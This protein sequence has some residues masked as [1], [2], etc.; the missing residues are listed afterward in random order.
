MASISEIGAKST[1]KSNGNE[2]ESV[3]ITVRIGVFFDGTNNNRAQVMLGRMNKEKNA[4]KALK[5]ENKGKEH[6]RLYKEYNELKD[7]NDEII[8]AMELDKLSNEERSFIKEADDK[9]E[10]KRKVLE[11]Q[12]KRFLGIGMPRNLG[13]HMQSIGFTNIAILERF[14]Q[15]TEQSDYTYKVY[16][17]G[18]GTHAK[19]SKGIDITGLAAGQGSAGVV[20]KVWDA[21]EAINTKTNFFNSDSFSGVEYVFDVFGFSRGATEARLFVDLCCNRENRPS[22]LRKGIKK[23]NKKFSNKKNSSDEK[24]LF[25]NQKNIKFNV[26]IYD[27]VASVGV[28]RDP[29]WAPLALSVPVTGV[30]L[31]SRTAST[32]HDEN[33]KDLGLN[34]VA[35]DSS[36]DKVVHICALDEY[37]ENFALCALPSGGKVEQFFMP[38]IHTDIGG[39]ELPGFRD[40]ISMPI[41]VMEKHIQQNVSIYQETPQYY[42]THE[43]LKI[44]KVAPL[45][46]MVEMT[47]ENLKR[48]GWLK[49]ESNKPKDIKDVDDFTDDDSVDSIDVRRYSVGIY[50]NL[51]LA[52]MAEQHNDVFNDNKIKGK[53]SI[54]GELPKSFGEMKTIWEGCNSNYGHCYFPKSEEQY[55][56]LRLR[57]LHFSS[58]AGSVNGPHYNDDYCYER[59]LYTESGTDI[60]KGG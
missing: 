58:S 2:N 54:H 45:N 26:G 33:V 7:E 56:D 52:I 27:T 5:K 42:F 41:K 50:S 32:F 37:R 30:E 14:Y 12:S 25:P 4:L 51:P 46:E 21:M 17:T 48:L 8:S 60:L 24:V 22:V 6:D 34:T 29:Q 18:S 9:A 19:V 43:R 3:E 47:L 38:G 15:P 1:K 59:Q 28:I 20:Q 57:Y 16:V 23:Y 10:A 55:K 44:R 13:T 36:V 40:A 53:H 35:H 11:K 39:S 49:D 31:V